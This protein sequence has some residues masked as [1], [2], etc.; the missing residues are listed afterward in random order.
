MSRTFTCL[1]CGKTLP[2][3]PR[4]KKQ[5]Y[6]SALACQNARK[7]LYDRKINPT[8]K[9]KLLQ[10]GRNKRWRDSYPAHEYQ[11]R[12]RESHSEYANRN[13]EQQRLRNKK[14]QK[15]SESMIVKT[16]AL[17]LQPLRDGF[18]AGFKVK[19]GKIVKTDT[20]MLQMQ[21]QAGVKAF[22]LLNPG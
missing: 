8:S 18:Y 19:S 4:L 2:R 12:Y 9:G 22:S 13:V 10:R 11:K 5:K 14:R 3:N 20:L 16:D 7:R 21:A 17:L 15:E 6:C 1:V